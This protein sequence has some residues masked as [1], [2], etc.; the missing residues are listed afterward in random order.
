MSPRKPRCGARVEYVERILGHD[1]SVEAVC[2]RV[3]GHP[4]PHRSAGRRYE[5]TDDDL[6]PSPADCQDE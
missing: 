4:P 3:S 5:W 2:T 6:L 1:V